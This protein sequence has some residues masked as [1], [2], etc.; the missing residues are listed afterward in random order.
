MQLQEIKLSK[1]ILRMLSGFLSCIICM[2]LMF[3]IIWFTNGCF[4]LQ[5]GVGCSISC[6]CEGCK[7]AFGRKDG[8]GANNLHEYPLETI[9]NSP[10]FPPLL[11]VFPSKLILL[12]LHV[13]LFE[14]FLVLNSYFWNSGSTVLGTE[15]EPEEE[16]IEKVEKSVDKSL[17]KTLIQRDEEQN[18]P[19][20]ALPATPLRL[21]RFNFQAIFISWN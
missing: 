19:D 8:K 15:A 9:I 21:C 13:L 18:N 1:E 6:R 20:S 11:F 16:E 2:V 4:P 5:G 7:N 10:P 17:Q 12:C 14:I 3:F